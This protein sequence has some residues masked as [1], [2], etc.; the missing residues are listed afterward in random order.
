MYHHFESLDDVRLA[1]LQSLI[2]DFL[3]LG[4]NENQFSTLEAYLVHVGDQTFNAMGSKPVE[5]K[6][7]MAFVQLAM[8]EPAFGESMKT[9]TQSSL[10]RYADAI[11]YLFPSLSDGNVSVIVQIIDAHFGGS[12]IHW[13]L[14]DDPEQCRKNWRFLCRMICNSLKQGV[15]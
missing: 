9:L 1:A 3:F 5:M 12:M 2:D 6:A 8:F 13:Y 10:Q 15:L 4:D 11:R 14:L 7:L